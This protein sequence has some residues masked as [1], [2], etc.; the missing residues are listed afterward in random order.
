LTPELI[1]GDLPLSPEE[2]AAYMT[3]HAR[4]NESLAARSREVAT[5]VG[6]RPSRRGPSCRPIADAC[7]PGR[8]AAIEFFLHAASCVADRFRDRPITIVDIGAGA[9][10]Q[11]DAFIDRGC[12]GRYIAIDIA[13]DPKWND[14]PRAG[15]ERSL[16]VGD[17]NALDLASLPAIDVL[18]SNTALEHIRDDVGA[19]RALSTRLAPRAVQAHFVPGEAALPLYGPH[20]FRQYSPWCL[21]GLFPG[22]EILRYGGPACAAVHRDWITPATRDGRSRRDEDPAAYRRLRDEAIDR[23]ERE[24]NTPAIMYG[25]LLATR[26]V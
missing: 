7:S 11:L 25:V 6:P 22:G 18:V 2:R 26:Q 24:G 16:I 13:R 23:D 10:G 15:F 1:S 12:R 4:R 21:A 20:G 14:G 8:V 19:V 5:S 9:G 17:V 3:H